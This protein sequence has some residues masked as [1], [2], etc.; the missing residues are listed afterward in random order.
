MPGR[1]KGNGLLMKKIYIPLVLATML[2]ATT[3]AIAEEKKYTVWVGG[4]LMVE[5]KLEGQSQPLTVSAGFAAVST[6]NGGGGQG[7]GGGHSVKFGVAVEAMMY[8][9]SSYSGLAYSLRIGSVAG[10]T[11]LGPGVFYVSRPGSSIAFRGG[12]TLTINSNIQ[13][14][15][16]EIGIGWQF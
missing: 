5:M 10:N 8:K 7:G 3:S 16:P 1:R 11:Y 13:L 4:S 15:T 9:N 6:K 2:G 12:V 14:F